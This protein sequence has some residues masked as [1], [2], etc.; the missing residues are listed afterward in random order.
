[1]DG[2]ARLEASLTAENLQQWSI[3]SQLREVTVELPRF[4]TM[5]RKSLNRALMSMGLVDAFTQDKADFSGIDGYQQWLFLGEILHEAVIDMTEEGTKA[6]AATAT[7]FLGGGFPDPDLPPVLFRADHPFVYIIYEHHTGC[8][9][10][11][12]RMVDPRK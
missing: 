8:T 9:L 6:A 10:F 2:L 5:Y 12:G 4:K 7:I 11:I 1:M 3:C